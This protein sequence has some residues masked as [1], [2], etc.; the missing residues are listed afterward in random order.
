MGIL[1]KIDFI[2][3]LEKNKNIE[4]ENKN[5]KFGK[6]FLI[7]FQHRKFLKRD[8]KLLK[9]DDERSVRMHIEKVLL[10]EKHKYKIYENTSYGMEYQNNLRGRKYPNE[11]LKAEYVRELNEVLSKHPKIKE[12][13]DLKIELKRNT[14]YTYFIVVLDNFRT[15]RWESDL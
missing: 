13:R 6:T 9:T 3:I 12:I 11:F 2:E 4:E 5:N 8:G 14:L 1:P 15:F 10:T 7:D